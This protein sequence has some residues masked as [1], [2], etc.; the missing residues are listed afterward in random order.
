MWWCA[1]V[2]CFVK[3]ALC[4]AAVSFLLLSSLQFWYAIIKFP[5]PFYSFFSLTTMGADHWS[6]SFWFYATRVK[7]HCYFTCSWLY[8]LSVTCSY[9]QWM[10]FTLTVYPVPWWRHLCD[11]LKPISSFTV[12][13]FTTQRPRGSV[14]PS[15]RRYIQRMSWPPEKKTQQWSRRLNSTYMS[16]AGGKRWSPFPLKAF[17]LTVYPPGSDSTVKQLLSNSNRTANSGNSHWKAWEQHK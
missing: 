8:L 5:S 3:L 9:D 12:F 13:L 10:S 14:A 15:S 4:Q 2:F 16:S 17:S 11:E 6:V 7:A 1:T